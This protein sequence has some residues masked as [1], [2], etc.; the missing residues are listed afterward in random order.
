M[1]K[2]ALLT[3]LA[4]ILLLLPHHLRFFSNNPS[5]AGEESYYHATL[6]K[7]II[8]NGYQKTL[9]FAIEP[10]NYF[11]QTYHV[12]SSP[13]Y[14]LFGNFAFTLLPVLLA[15]LTF[16]LFIVFL[17]K[18]KFAKNKILWILLCF[19]LS[20][21]FISLGF[22][23]TPSALNLALILTSLI[24]L[25][26]SKPLFSAPLL[27]LASADSMAA[28]IASA[29][30]IIYSAYLTKKTKRE[31]LWL[32][33][34]PILCSLFIQ[35]NTPFTISTSL[36]PFFSDLGGQFG[37]GTFALILMALFA[38]FSWPQKQ[39]AII[40]YCTLYL[41]I[42]A[43]FPSLL[44]Y[45]LPITATLCGLTLYS[46][47]TKKWEIPSLR[48][49]TLFIIFLGLLFST[50]SHAKILY[51][52]DPSFELITALST[53]NKGNILTAQEYA[54]Y[55]IFFGHKALLHPFST[56]QEFENQ[57]EDAIL[58]FY[59]TNLQKTSDLLHKNNVTY[60]L[61]T[62]QMKNGL[63]WDKDAFGLAFLVK[64]NETFKK[65]PTDSTL[66]VYLVK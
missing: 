2:Y 25:L 15:I 12:I 49:L 16:F 18:Q 62:P 34:I 6:A 54:N 20:P 3:I 30:C 9:L 32:L 26:K 11:P 44:P 36:V 22:Y 7:N 45:A 55:A 53:I 5:F 48:R 64:N 50:I 31:H 23:N 1:K 47:Y 65:I 57:R 56:K 10:Y 33:L 21:A 58:A 60:V 61:I 35:Y 40:I 42:C 29:F 41:A 66:E 51:E 27:F 19:I 4:I 59:S 38:L 24:L 39:Y 17:R 46:L 43:V 13:A 52:E 63:V 8:E 37:I 14:Y 28:A